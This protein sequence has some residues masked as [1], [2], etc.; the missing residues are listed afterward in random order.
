MDDTTI[1]GGKIWTGTGWIRG[2]LGLKNGKVARLSIRPEPAAETIDAR[3]LLVLPGIIDPHVHFGLG[4]GTSATADGFSGGSRAAAFGGVTTVIDFLDPVRTAAAMVSAFGLRA[5]LAKS[6][7]VDYGFHATLARPSDPASPLVETALALGLPSLKVF[8]AYSS[9]DRRTDDRTIGALLAAGARAGTT[10]LV[11]A[12]NESLMDLSPGVPVARHEASRP[13]LCEVT[14]VLTLAELVRSTGGRLYVVHTNAGTTVERLRSLH[15][16]LLG[17]TLFLETCSHYL[18]WDSARYS[19]PDGAR[20]TM[21]PPL[22]PP[23]EREKLFRHFDDFHTLGTDH[24]AYHTTQKDRATT[25]LIPMGI[26]GAEFLLPSIWSRFG[27]RCLPKLTE[28]T[29]KIHGLWPQK[30]NL[31]PG[32]DADVVLFDPRPRWRVESHHGDADHT[33]WAGEPMAGR[34][35]STLLR[36][37]FLVRDGDFLGGEGRF[38]KRRPTK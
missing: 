6:S 22:R 18:L 38:I 34:V 35:V 13:A 11:H 33:A 28:Q 20:F 26:G 7:C 21:T 12:E 36:G 19:R 29:A 8:T 2:C 17:R 3:G 23:E 32:A 10:L 27:D 25:D 4:A 5:S 1:A 16:D 37:H 15:S 9:T 24:C 14:S 30:G 31:F